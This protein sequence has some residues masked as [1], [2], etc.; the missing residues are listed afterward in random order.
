MQN[1]KSIFSKYSGYLNTGH[2]NTVHNGLIY[3]FFGLFGY[4]L[5]LSFW[6]LDHN[7]EFEWFGMFFI[8]WI[9]DFSP[10]FEPCYENRTI[11]IPNRD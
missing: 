10:V 3:G 11:W 7:A 4:D 6:S 9:A 5:Q 8:I 1:W 2:L